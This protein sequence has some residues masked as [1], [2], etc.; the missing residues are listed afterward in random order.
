MGC[1]VPKQS[2][3]VLKEAHVMRG[4]SYRQGAYIFMSSQSQAGS[5]PVS[6]LQVEGRKLG[7]CSSTMPTE[8]T[9]EVNRI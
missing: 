2:S 4:G 7:M 8:V 6:L 1:V 3:E 5:W 9:S